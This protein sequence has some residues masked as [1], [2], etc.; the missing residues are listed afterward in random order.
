MEPVVPHTPIRVL[1]SV[2]EF[3]G[4]V[5]VV[6]DKKTCLNLSASWRPTEKRFL[7]EERELC[8]LYKFYPYLRTYGDNTGMEVSFELGA[9]QTLTKAKLDGLKA[10]KGRWD[11]WGIMLQDPL[12]RVVK[13]RKKVKPQEP[14]VLEEASWVLYTDGSKRKDD[15]DNAFLGYILKRNDQEI[16]RKKGSRPSA[17][18]ESVPGRNGSGQKEKNQKIT[19]NH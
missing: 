1:V 12:V 11:V 3:G 2:D 15:G 14:E 6:Q 16:E 13:S 5:R 8:V 19:H 4:N 18:S 9:T 10:L 7:N 17:R